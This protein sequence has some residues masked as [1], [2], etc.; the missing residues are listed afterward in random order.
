MH[1]IM[2]AAVLI[3]LPIAALGA[4]AQGVWRTGATSDGS[5]IEVTVGPCAS[6]A[7][8]T[9]GVVTK[10]FRAGAED[11]SY[12]YLGETIVSNMSHDGN[13]QYAGGVVF[14]PEN[15]KSYKSKMTV[16]DD[17]LDVEGCVA[18]ICEGEN[19]SRVK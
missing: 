6:D 7:G 1:E 15:G 13:G 3:A 2:A 19:W 14:D 4:G 12:Q 10:A 8:K 18:F 9:C 11:S 17:S 5:H 16:K